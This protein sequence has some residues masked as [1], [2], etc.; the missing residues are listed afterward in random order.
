VRVLFVCTGNSARSQMAEAL[1]QQAA[2]DRVEVASAGS[3]PKPVHPN[4]VKVLAERGLD[5][6]GRR[7]KSFADFAGQRFD[8]VVTLCDKVRERCPEFA[9]D[10]ETMHWSVEDPSDAAGTDR[11][12]YQ[13]FRRTAAELD[14]RIGFLVA[15]IDNAHNS[16]EHTP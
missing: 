7:S 4:A 5:I 10:D 11:Q 9:E 2:G 3:A 14:A 15:L 16:K 1:L 6:G 13:R 12:T 8:Y